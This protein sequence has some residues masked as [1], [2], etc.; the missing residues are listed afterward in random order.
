MDVSTDHSWCSGLSVL[1]TWSVTD[2][3]LIKLDRNYYPSTCI[4]LLCGSSHKK[5]YRIP[6]HISLCQWFFQSLW[7]CFISYPLA[8][9]IN[10]LLSHIFQ[11]FWPLLILFRV[12][13]HLFIHIYYPY[14]CS[15][16]GNRGTV[17]K[18]N[19]FTLIDMTLV[20][21]FYLGMFGGPT[22]VLRCK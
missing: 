4:S 14:H 21:C 15:L 10:C 16:K 17:M 7:T 2:F 22:E 3:S 20:G 6:Q 8:S 12:V 5:Y 9:C 18:D 1:Y 11:S 13:S 19:A